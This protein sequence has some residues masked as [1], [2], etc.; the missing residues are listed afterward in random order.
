MVTPKKEIQKTLEQL[1]ETESKLMKKGPE[2]KRMFL[3]LYDV[4]KGSGI[5]AHFGN[6]EVDDRKSYIEIELP[7]WNN[8]RYPRY[9]RVGDVELPKESFFSLKP[10]I[11]HRAVYFVEHCDDG[12]WIEPE[13]HYWDEFTEFDAYFKNLV[14]SKK[15]K[16]SGVD[17]E[18]LAMLELP[19][20]LAEHLK[21]IN[22]I[23]GR[24]KNTYVSK[25]IEALKNAVACT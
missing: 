21:Q 17:S 18:I 25:G 24:V 10:N 9:F 4:L 15:I 11:E 20:R 16:P 6:Y 2:I 3:E 7:V 19:E 1:T 23:N 13:M 14:K 22:H 8:I 12:S 5:H